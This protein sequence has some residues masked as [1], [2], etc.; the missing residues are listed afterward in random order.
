MSA[1]GC[2]KPAAFS[3]HKRVD[4]Q[5]VLPSA[6]RPRRPSAGSSSARA[7]VPSRVV[8]ATNFSTLLSASVKGFGG[9][10]GQT[11]AK[12]SYVI[13]PVSSDHDFPILAPMTLAI[14]GSLPAAH[15]PACSK[16]PRRS[17]SGRAGACIT[18][19]SVM[20]SIYQRGSQGPTLRRR[21]LVESVAGGAPCAA[22]PIHF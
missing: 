8:E 14:S 5:D 2:E 4:L 7:A 10:F 22:I 20:C 6:W 21:R 16:L 15:Q 17:S 19:S 18:P 11:L 13:R 3:E 1:P 9:R 12:S